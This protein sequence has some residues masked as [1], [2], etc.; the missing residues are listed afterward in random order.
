MDVEVL[1]RHGALERVERHRRDAAIAEQEIPPAH[2]VG[3][4]VAQLEHSCHSRGPPAEPAAAGVAPG[5]VAGC[6]W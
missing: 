5:G 4:L 6:P 2:D 1:E 3:E